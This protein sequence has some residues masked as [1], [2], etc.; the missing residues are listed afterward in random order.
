VDGGK[1]ERMV[2]AGDVLFKVVWIILRTGNSKKL[3]KERD[4][5]VS[6]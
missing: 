1:V 3:D 6:E 5:R 2:L 4:Q